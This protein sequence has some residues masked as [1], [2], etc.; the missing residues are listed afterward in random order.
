MK[1]KY[2]P[3][4]I[5]LGFFSSVCFSQVN[6]DINKYIENPQ[7]VGENKEKP[8]TILVPYHNVELALSRKKE[9]SKFYFSL[10]GQWKFK[11]QINP[12]L[13]P[14]DFYTKD[15]D[16]KK[17]DNITVP[18]VWQM[19][20]YDHNI[21]RNVPMEFYPYDPPKVPDDIN[22]TGLYRK[23]IN[24]P[25]EWNGRKIFLHFDGIQSAGFVWLNGEYVGYHEDGM[26]PAEFDITDKAAEGENV[27]SVMVI[28]WS[29]GS[30]LED[31]DMFR[32][33]GIY[34][35][36][37]IYSKPNVTLRDLFIKTDLDENYTNADLILDLTLLNYAKSS[38][39]VKVKYSLYDNSKKL[40]FTESSDK[41]DVS[42]ETKNT[43]TKKVTAPQKWSDEK[44]NLYTLVIEVLD[45]KGNTVEI[46]SQRV[47][48]RELEIKNGIA[49]LNGVPVYFRG[50]NRHE[51]NP[52]NV[53]T[54]TK[55]LM[56]EDIK[57]L[58]QFN[59]NAVRTCHYPNDPLWYDLCDEYGI[60]LQDEVNAECHY[61][62]NTFPE[63]EEYFDSFMDRFVRMV[64]RD[65]NHP[66]V[67]MWSTGNECGLAK[68]HYA[69]ADF[70]KKFDPTRFLMHQSNWPDGEAPY[71]DIIGP[72]YPTPSRLREIGLGT[73]KPVVMGEYA[74]AMGNSLGNFDEFWETIYSIPKLQGGFVWDWVDQGLEV[75]ARFVKD[76]SSNDFQC[77]VMGSPEI[78]KGVEGNAFKL[79]GIDDWVEVYDDPRLDITG[80]N[81]VIEAVVFPQKFY[82][83]NSI[84]AKAFQFG[85]EQH[86][87]DTLSFHINSYDNSLKIKVP[88]DWY[89]GF[90]K[91][92]AV[93]DGMNMT[94]FIDGKEFGTKKY[95]EKIYTTH[96]P[97]YI[98]KDAYKNTDAHLGWISDFIFDE[99]K[100]FNDTKTENAQ[101]V[102]W[103]KFDEVIESN[104]TYFTYGIFP[105][106]H[107]GMITPDRK[108][109][110]E[111]WQAKHSMSPVRFYSEDP[112]SGIFKAV[113]KFSFTNLN[114]LNTEW[115]LYKNGRLEKSGKVELDAAPQSQK[116][117]QIPVPQNLDDNDYVIELSCKLKKDEPFRGKGFEVDF[118]QF[119]LKEKKNSL[120]Q[121]NSSKKNSKVK[122][123][124]NEKEYS[125]SSGDVKYLID[126]TSGALSMF[127]K[128]N[129]IITSMNANVWHAPTSNE[130]MNWGKA[131]AE[132]WYR[133]GLNEYVN[134]TESVEFKTAADSSN[135]IVKLKSYM[136]FPRTSDYIL[137]EFEYIFTNKGEVT[138]KHKMTPLGYFDVEWLP[139]IGLAMKVPDSYQTIK[140]YGRGPYE[141]YNDRR[142]GSKIG[143]YTAQIDQVQNP[144]T[145]PQDYGNYSGVKWVEIKNQK[146]SGIKIS[147][148]KE[149]D[150]SAVPFYNLDR[151]RYT[152]QL[153][154]DDFSRV[155]IN[156]AASGVGDTPNPTMP[157][158][159][160]YPQVHSNTITIS[161]LD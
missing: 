43:L 105:F 161:L 151:S 112:A 22:P 104:E 155:K 118:T 101:P 73:S 150:F 100:I 89:T 80:K 68:P 74:H 67:V 36:A 134:K 86:T 140:W 92:K 20:G 23:T 109:Q 24:V 156:Y 124:E 93:Y 60:Y 49:M 70:I 58:K 123:G 35:N 119:V 72:R 1:K 79:S 135:V 149:I 121:N 5:L 116:E 13:V 113:N 37:Y 122:V 127:E 142:T 50:T 76:F 41:I 17:W 108:A 94:L 30:Y 154:Q 12:S 25:E 21:Y 28:R 90:H 34:R 131:E 7:V 33:S 158:Y 144:Y 56:I 95:H 136:T 125:I 27:I 44:P 115:F 82:Q 130:K 32:F 160:V 69:M 3:L 96:Y 18:S 4:I 132:D 10:N 54:L 99:V 8:T 46:L 19:Q 11:W 57:L 47:G 152:Y 111:L 133:M 71:V 55:E 84:A 87:S 106:C 129:T 110:P 103:L 159:R 53:R 64:Q 153:L 29:D 148:E 98:G 14:K 143:I 117:F 138:I 63:R 97:V 52:K 91:I 85:I 9:E 157:Q 26:T 16:D 102:L 145:E 77:G 139:C 2:F 75:K 66:S 59:L 83:E 45:E 107:N 38:S 61:T 39:T 81:L 62:E 146:G 51:H 88:D 65:K 15:L 31:Q 114:E 147:V 48:F 128:G 141:N 120:A 40:V 6:L 78:V 126:K 42:G 137:N